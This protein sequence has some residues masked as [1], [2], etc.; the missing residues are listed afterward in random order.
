MVSLVGVEDDILITFTVAMR[1]LQLD[2]CDFR[3]G[4]KSQ[5]GCVPKVLRFIA[6]SGSY[7][8]QDHF[9]STDKVRKI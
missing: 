4:H 7:V 5:C 6:M 1:R 3:M 8:F 2:T 9:Y